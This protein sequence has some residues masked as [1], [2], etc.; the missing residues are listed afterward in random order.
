[1]GGLTALSAVMGG[2][3]VGA[4]VAGI[5][6]GQQAAQI[7]QR[8]LQ[9]QLTETQLKST[10]ESIARTEKMTAI[11]SQQQANASASN[12]SL[13]SP[14]FK[15]VS[16]KSYE[17]YLFDQTN[18]ATNLQIQED[19]IQNQIAQSRLSASAGLAGGIAN[20]AIGAYSAFNPAMGMA[21]YGSQ[22]AL[23][24]GNT[25]MGANSLHKFSNGAF[26]THNEL[27]G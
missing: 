17:N 7:Q 19:M 27:W 23:F 3:S 16:T 18:A 12:V 8:N 6:A 24:G 25:S 13:A 21:S 4:K 5:A 10:Q 9:R 2:L 15:S 14:S 11:L 22:Q 20:A 1:M 26:S